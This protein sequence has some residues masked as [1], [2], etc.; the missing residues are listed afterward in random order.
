MHIAFQ[1]F[2]IRRL[3]YHYIGHDGVKI[4]SPW[5]PFPLPKTT[6]SSY[7]MTWH[8]RSIT[9]WS[10]LN[11]TWKVVVIH[12]YLYV[13][14]LWRNSLRENEIPIPYVVNSS[15]YSRYLTHCRMKSHSAAPVTSIVAPD[16]IAHPWWRHKMETFSALLAI[17]WG[18]SPHKDQWRRALMFSLISTW[19]NGWVNN[20]DAGDLRD[21]RTHYDVIV[22]S[23]ANPVGLFQWTLWPPF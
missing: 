22:M 6:N 1:G 5:L 20:G 7:L 15:P 11:A 13:P 2:V 23:A 10:V 12:T 17:C 4:Y 21:H 9:M 19:I 14:F 3:F 16:G 8:L 18:N